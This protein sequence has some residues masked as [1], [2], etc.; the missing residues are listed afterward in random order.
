M[1]RTALLLT[2]LLAPATSLAENI[3]VYKCVIKG[4]AT[5]S[6]FPCATDAEAITLKNINVTA[7]YNTAEKSNDIA[8]TSVDDYLQIQQIKRDIKRYQLAITE[9]K[10]QFAAEKQQISY[11]TQ[12]QANRLGAASI[13]DAIATKTAA[14]QQ[15][16]DALIT[17][18]QQ[19][20][21]TLK[22]QQEKLTQRP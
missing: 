17:Q 11:I 13:S 3:T 8:D 5:F 21:D 18:A 16:Y 7:A 1:F 12:D 20:I 19:Q 22:Q 10:Q 2:C 14:L 4:I 9:Y 6:Q 15:T